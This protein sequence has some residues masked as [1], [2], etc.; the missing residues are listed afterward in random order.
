M[1]KKILLAIVILFFAFFS[2]VHGYKYEET[3]N[4]SFKISADGS[5]SLKNINGEVKVLTYDGDEIKV[6]AEKGSNDKTY[7]EELKIVFEKSGN[8]LKIYTERK[9]KNCRVTID[10]LVKIP[11]RFGSTIISVVN[12]KIVADGN[13]KDIKLKTVNGK[14]VYSGNFKKGEISSVNGSVHVFTEDKVSGD[15][16][17]TTVNGS[18][19]IELNKDSDIE[20]KAGTVNGSIKSDFNLKKTKGFIGSK[21]TG[22]V[23]K[24]DYYIKLKTV[25]GSIKILQ[26]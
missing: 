19:S 22:S 2:F 23:N 8:K 13:L 20:V 16:S 21:A 12:G 3:I 10:Y 17:V 9:R 14:I 1:K 6:R 4:K 24:G 7:F 26:N 5:F 18:V 15:I 25:N 11:E